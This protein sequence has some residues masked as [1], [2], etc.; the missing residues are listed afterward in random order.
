MGIPQFRDAHLVRRQ[1][2]VGY[3]K[4]FGGDS[5]SVK[6]ASPDPIEV[7]VQKN[8]TDKLIARIVYSGPVRAPIEAGQRSADQGLARR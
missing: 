5:G 8:G 1:Q 7:M 6:L 3:A 2:P 4:V